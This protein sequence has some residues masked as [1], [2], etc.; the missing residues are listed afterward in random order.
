MG[1][2]HSG[3]SMFSSYVFEGTVHNYIP[4]AG[5]SET[6]TSYRYNS[7]LLVEYGG[8]VTALWKII[9][10]HAR[11]YR[12]RVCK[13]LLFV[14][15]SF[16]EV[17]MEETRSAYMCMLYYFK[18]LRCIPLCVVQHHAG[19]DEPPLLGWGEIKEKLQLALLLKNGFCKGN[20][21]I[22]R[23]VY[24]ESSVLHKSIRRILDW[25]IDT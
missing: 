13:V 6:S 11:K 3:K 10:K 12:R 2:Q 19:V 7:L 23:L 14:D 4:T 18:E 8:I 9:F 16:D 1:L 21:A 17:Q 25:I 20:I 5:Y 15:G 22:I 24:G